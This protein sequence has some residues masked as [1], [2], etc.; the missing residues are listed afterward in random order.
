MVVQFSQKKFYNLKFRP[1]AVVMYV[2]HVTVWGLI[3]QKSRMKMMFVTSFKFNE[4][5][6]IHRQLVP[7][8][9]V[10]ENEST[11][12]CWKGYCKRL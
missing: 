4:Q 12:R 10:M 1:I 5:V 2:T 6:V 8:G 7:E 3:L 11:L 9:K